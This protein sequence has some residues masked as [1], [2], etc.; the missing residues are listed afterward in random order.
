[1]IQDPVSH[2]RQPYDVWAKGAYWKCGPKRLA[3]S[4][5]GRTTVQLVNGAVFVS[6]CALNSTRFVS[7]RRDYCHSSKLSVGTP[8]VAVA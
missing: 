7:F 2:Q 1:V 6:S 8:L 4:S 3:M 5:L